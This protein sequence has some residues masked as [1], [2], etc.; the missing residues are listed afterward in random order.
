MTVARIQNAS[1]LERNGGDTTECL[2]TFTGYARQ[3]LSSVDSG[4]EDFA[5]IAQLLRQAFA[6]FR[7]HGDR[8]Y[9]PNSLLKILTFADYMDRV[10]AG[11][12]PFRSEAC[13][14]IVV[15]ETPY[16][17]DEET[18]V[19]SGG[20]LGY[21]LLLPDNRLMLAVHGSKR[22]AKIGTALLRFVT[23][24]IATTPEVW[25]HRNNR[26]GAHFLLSLEMSPWTI[27]SAGAVQYSEVTPESED[28]GA[29]DFA[30]DVDSL[31]TL[32]RP[33]VSQRRRVDEV[34][35][36]R[37]SR[38]RFPVDE[39][40][41][42]EVSVAYDPA[43]RSFREERERIEAELEQAQDRVDH[44]NQRVDTTTVTAWYDAFP[45]Q[46]S[47]SGLAWRVERT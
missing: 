47:N 21:T 15:A 33:Q 1:W 38:P 11:A 28:A 45:A 40:T 41:P 4:T 27:N 23:T 42:L 10:V 19:K 13:P 39:L 6:F 26:T 18:E 8:R 46:A 44:L 22:R 16:T 9:S 34:E 43:P 20:V 30:D 37:R 3:H 5:K 14:S 7:V 36:G 2:P 32:R 12:E 25:V 35:G 17:Y 24:Y 31:L 29:T